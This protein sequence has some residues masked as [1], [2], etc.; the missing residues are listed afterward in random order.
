MRQII[1]TTATFITFLA[2]QTQKKDD[3]SFRVD[4]SVLDAVFTDTLSGISIHIPKDWQ[5][6]EEKTDSLSLKIKEVLRS[7]GEATK[8]QKIYLDQITQQSSLSIIYVDEK[9]SIKILAAYQN[10]EAVLNG[11]KKWKEINKATFRYRGINFTQFILFN[12]ELVNIKLVCSKA[13]SLQFDFLLT[14]GEYKKSIKKIESSIGSI[15]G[16]H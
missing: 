13:K 4:Y 10:P 1:F 11:K 2:C 14:Q 7:T 8:V 9:D 15:D 6:I 3:V 5:S 16:G 12:N